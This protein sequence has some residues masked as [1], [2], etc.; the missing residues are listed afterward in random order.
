MDTE[1]F[2]IEVF[3]L[4]VCRVC[5]GWV[6][7][8]WGGWGWGGGLGL[9]RGVGGGGVGK[10]TLHPLLVELQALVEWRTVRAD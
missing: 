1:F 4:S 10:F 5:G 7:W 2:S 6:G 9:E 3:L 8:G